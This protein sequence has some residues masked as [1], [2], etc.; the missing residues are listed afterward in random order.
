MFFKSHTNKSFLIQLIT[1]ECA[2]RMVLI[3][4][5]LNRSFNFLTAIPKDPDNR[6]HALEDNIDYWLSAFYWF[7]AQIL[8]QRY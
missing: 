8:S 7:F 3:R 6:Y 4:T 2:P 1:V 5:F